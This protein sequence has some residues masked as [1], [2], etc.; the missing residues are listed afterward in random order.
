MFAYGLVTTL[1]IAVRCNT[2]I[3]PKSVYCALV[4]Y[5][6]KYVCLLATTLGIVVRCN[7]AIKPES[8][9]CVLMTCGQVFVCYSAITHCRSL[10]HNHQT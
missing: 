6:V 1:G 3:T 10:R 8:V 4:A 5:G 9:R 7:I 2:T